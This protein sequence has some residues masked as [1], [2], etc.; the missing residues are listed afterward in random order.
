LSPAPFAHPPRPPSLTR[1][2]NKFK[3]GAITRV[4]P[5]E[6][7]FAKTSNVTRFLAGA[8]L[9]GLPQ[10]DL[11]QRDDLL[12]ASS[13]SLGRVANTVIALCK[14]AEPPGRPPPRCPYL[15]TNVD[16]CMSSPDLLNSRTVS[17]PLQ[18]HRKRSSQSGIPPFL[19]LPSHPSEDSNKS[20]EPTI[21]YVGRRSLDVTDSQCTLRENAPSP[22]PPR[23]PFRP[24]PSRTS[25]MSTQTDSTNA[26][27]SLLDNQA[28]TQF[29][30]TVRTTTT[31]VTSIYPAAESPFTRSDS[32]LHLFPHSPEEYQTPF[33]D[34]PRTSRRQSFDRERIPDR[35]Y[36]IGLN[37][38][39]YDVLNGRRRERRSSELCNNDL[40]GVEELDEGTRRGGRP[41]YSSGSGAEVSPRTDSPAHGPVRP[42]A[43][44]QPST[45]QRGHSL[46]SN[47]SSEQKVGNSSEQED[48]DKDTTPRSS[49]LP[50]QV[51]IDLSTTPPPS[52]PSKP[53]GLPYR[54]PMHGH[55]HSVDTV[56]HPLPLLP[57]F[58]SGPQ[59]TK[60]KDLNYRGSSPSSLSGRDSSTPSPGAN[61]SVSSSALMKRNSS[62][63]S[64]RGSYV[65][66][67]G[68]SM[69][70]GSLELEGPYATG[71]YA[72]G[73]ESEAAVSVPALIRVPFPRTVSGEPPS[74]GPGSRLAA[75][76]SSLE[77]LIP[78]EMSGS[79]TLYARNQYRDR[80]NSE[81]G[82]SRPR[83]TRP[84]SFDDGG[85]KPRRSR[86][87]SMVNLGTGSE[88]L[89]REGSVHGEIITLVFA[90]GKEHD[91]VRVVHDYWCVVSD[92]FFSF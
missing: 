3:P 27:S 39:T 49:S 47:S 86:Y 76:P 21:P 31:N 75:L 72:T 58:P 6:D 10:R 14:L 61:S 73:Q 17:P 91:Y 36:A 44:G 50:K 85:F 82:T 15:T 2:L 57:R 42:Q 68:V 9:F 74:S 26:N 23:S 32:N 56:A 1:L 70:V 60:N 24:N 63:P 7:G 43:K 48:K 12:E 62:R 5:R 64:P 84:N 51:E 11:F 90:D 53:A 59:A 67:A 66:K 37:G 89:T 40:S 33:T 88:A 87:E 80:Y 25:F 13:E 22:I 45:D 83:R 4:D 52:K 81:M 35:L 16:V 19:P 18:Q 71:P 92:G 30:S 78:A 28:S 79:G 29:F 55:R 34:L 8:K 38:S 54:R 65:P 46:Q 41:G 69:S 20:R 77:T